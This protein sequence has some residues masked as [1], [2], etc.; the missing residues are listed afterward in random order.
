MFIR[1]LPMVQTQIF[2]TGAAKSYIAERKKLQAQL[3]TEL[4]AQ[5]DPEGDEDVIVWGDLQKNGSSEEIQELKDMGY[6]EIDG[7]AP[8]V[9]NSKFQES[10]IDHL[11][12]NSKTRR[13]LTTE[14]DS[15][16]WN[17]SDHAML[18]SAVL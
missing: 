7:N 8:T 4:I 6:K 9:F 18:A 1:N 14:Y 13:L 17:I 3:W 16:V 15:S 5:A 2:S 10:C 11:L 12:L